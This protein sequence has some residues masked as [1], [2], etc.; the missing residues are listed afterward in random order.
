[1]SSIQSL[2]SGQ[3]D[4][5]VV[6]SELPVVVDFYAPWCGPCRMLVP[7][8]EALA[9]EYAGRVRFVK[10]NVDEEPHLAA[11]AE[12]RGVPTL[13]FVAGGL[14]VDAIVGLATPRDIRDKIEKLASPQAVPSAT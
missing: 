9:D 6:R 10:V 13:L 1:M 2:S 3:F 14:P 8:L 12:I 5:Q 7:F 11:Q 4:Q